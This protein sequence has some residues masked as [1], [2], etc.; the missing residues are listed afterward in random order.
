M[1]ELQWY[2][3]VSNLRDFLQNYTYSDG[4]KLFPYLYGRDIFKVNVGKGLVGD[5]PR[6]D[7]LLG[8][9]TP[10]DETHPSTTIGATIQLWLDLYITIGNDGVNDNGDN[11]YRQAFLCE[12]ELAERLTEFT[13]R[14]KKDYGIGVKLTMVGVLSDGDNAAPDNLY[15]RIVLDIEWRR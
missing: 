15:H 7:I 12:K 11:L 8:E 10:L 14:I 4:S 3:I 5:T 6:L 9:E 13:T 2:N 1:R